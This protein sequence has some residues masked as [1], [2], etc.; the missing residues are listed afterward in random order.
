[1]EGA[2]KRPERTM[3]LGIQVLFYLVC[4]KTQNVNT[5]YYN[6]VVSALPSPT[7]P[8]HV[9]LKESLF[10]VLSLS[11]ASH[12]QK[13]AGICGLTEQWASLKPKVAQTGWRR[14]RT[15]RF[16]RLSEPSKPALSVSVLRIPQ[17]PDS[18]EGEVYL[19]IRAR[20]CC[21]EI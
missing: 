11:A 14:R 20:Q 16:Y 3:M 9:C 18:T 5:E 12:P 2:E 10:A 19:L 7:E 17:M 21:L 15:Y 6:I 1:M 4:F 13:A 8:V